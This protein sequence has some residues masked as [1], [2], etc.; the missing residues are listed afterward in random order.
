[1][2]TRRGE[3]ANSSLPSPFPE[4]WYFVASRQSLR[5]TKLI[6]KTWMGEEIVAWSDE[7]GRVCVAEAYCVH[8]GSDLGPAAGGAHTWW[9]ARSVPSMATSTMPPASASPRP[10]P[11]RQGPRSCGSSRHRK[12][13]GLIFA[14]WGIGGREPQWSLHP[15]PPVQAGWSNQ[16][17]KTLR[18]PGHPQETTENSV[19]MAHFRYVPWLRQRGPQ[20]ASGD[21]RALPREPL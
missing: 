17:I 9:P 1:M 18:F 2:T 11:T 20:R 4:G 14:W 3:A 7:V 13:A 16:E 8:L 10:T 5:K 12:S 21:G 6:R 19:D 15:D